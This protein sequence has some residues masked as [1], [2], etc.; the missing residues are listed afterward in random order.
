[1]LPSLLAETR[2]H[3][4]PP[5]VEAS[6]PALFADLAAQW[7]GWQGERTWE[8]YEGG[9]RIAL[10]HDGVGH[11][12]ASVRLREANASTWSVHAQIPL[13]AGQLDRAAQELAAFFK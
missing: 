2:V 13:D 10:T 5:E 1:V 9:L 8:A 4:G 7:R 3:L 11:V 6:L 12:N